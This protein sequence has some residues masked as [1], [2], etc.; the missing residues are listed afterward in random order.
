MDTYSLLL[1]HG[2]TT[3]PIFGALLAIVLNLAVPFLLRVIDVH[4][5]SDPTRVGGSWR[6]PYVLGVLE[7]LIFFGSVWAGKYELAAGW[8]VF[9]VGTKWSAWQ[10]IVPKIS[11]AW[12]ERNTWAARV[13]SHFLVGTAAN[14][15]I[16]LA[17]VFVAR[18]L[19][20]R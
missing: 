20:L 11:D 18:H 7:T 10:H 4:V 5:K 1:G 2:T 13:V 16:A 3:R 9:K 14:A 8:L 17:A 19:S 12:E 6:A 15:V